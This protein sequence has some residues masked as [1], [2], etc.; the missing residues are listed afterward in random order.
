MEVGGRREDGGGREEGEREE[1]EGRT[2]L[3]NSVVTDNRKPFGL[4][5]WYRGLGS[6]LWDSKISSK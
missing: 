1:R 6:L 2:V 5:G 3:R 4:V